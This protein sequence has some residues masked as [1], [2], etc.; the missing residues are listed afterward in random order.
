MYYKS[1]ISMEIWLLLLPQT[2]PPQQYKLQGQPLNGQLD[3]NPYAVYSLEAIF[4]YNI[5][6]ME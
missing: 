1:Q 5:I 2:V 3:L 6:F 4:Y